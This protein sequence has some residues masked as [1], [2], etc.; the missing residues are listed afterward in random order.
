MLKKISFIIALNICRYNNCFFQEVQNGINLFLHKRTEYANRLNDDIDSLLSFGGH[1]KAKQ[2][3]TTSLSELQGPIPK[4]AHQM[5]KHLK[6]AKKYASN[7]GYIFYGKP[8]TGKNTLVQAIAK[9]SNAYLIEQCASEFMNVY[10]G[11]GAATVRELFQTAKDLSC[12]APVVIFI[13]EIDSIGMRGTIENS[14][15]TNTFNQLINC[16]NDV[17]GYHPIIVIA[18]TN[19]R[20]RIDSALTRSGRLQCVEVPLPNTEQRFKILMH[21]AA[22]YNCKINSELLKEVAKKSKGL[23]PASIEGIFK[24][25]SYIATERDIP[26]ISFNHLQEALTKEMSLHKERLNIEEKQKTDRQLNNDIQKQHLN[27]SKYQLSFGGFN[28][29]ITLLNFLTHLPF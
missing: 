28:T 10:I 5:V 22:K 18:A 7:P 24:Q 9:E 8:G 21:Y 16:M 6:N 3:C 2:T 4:E 26:K 17:K 11:K 12:H 25:A 20:E 27:H 1:K 14:E 29:A 13:D 19:C 23:C 15:A